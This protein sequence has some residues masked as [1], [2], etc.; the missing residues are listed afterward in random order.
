MTGLIS[1]DLN[2]GEVKKEEEKTGDEVT[3]RMKINEANKEVQIK[4]KQ[5]DEVHLAS[6]K[7]NLELEGIYLAKR[8]SKDYYKYF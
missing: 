2:L 8:K 3:K 6:K 1:T 4:T 5:A 7:R